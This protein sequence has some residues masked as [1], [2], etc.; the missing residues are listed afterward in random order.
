[1]KKRFLPCF[2]LLF[3]L[4]ANL[5]AGLSAPGPSPAPQSNPSADGYIWSA[6]AAGVGSWKDPS[7]LSILSL[8]YP[9]NSTT[10]TFD[11][12]GISPNG[13][14]RTLTVPNASGTLALL[15]TANVFTSLQSITV[16]NTQAQTNTITGL[17][18]TTLPGLQLTNTTAAA[19]GAQQV[20][21]S[22]RW[23]GQGYKSNATAA[24]QA[25]EFRAYVVPSQGT[26]VA[27]G[28]WVLDSSVNGGSWTSVLSVPE[29]GG[30]TLGGASNAGLTTPSVNINSGTGLVLNSSLSRI[31]SFTDG[32]IRMANNGSTS[33]GRLVLGVTNG[34]TIAPVPTTPSQITADQNNYNPTNDGYYQRWSTDASRSITGLVFTSPGAQIGGQT[35]VIVNV[36]SNNIVLV[37]ES[38]SS[39][40][41]NRFHNSTGADI[42]LAAD[43]EV[44]CWY[45]ATTA[46]WR[47]TKRGF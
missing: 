43:Q 38:A 18:A 20:S 22:L 28:T 31:Q 6:T 16:A 3:S 13:T 25:V 42:T 5:F 15:S 14:T 41:A 19:N 36:G 29:Q 11:L 40:A 10:V 1:M 46:R 9:T 12:T 47:V 26:T 17:G 30:L 33:F 24:S 45:D 37:N 23:S 7:T 39:T 44:N 34:G 21:P 32:D 2:A 27:T 4:G 35:H 8:N